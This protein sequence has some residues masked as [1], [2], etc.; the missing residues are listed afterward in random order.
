MNDA[1]F[2]VLYRQM[3]CQ[4]CG[5]R[6]D[7]EELDETFFPEYRAATPFGCLECGTVTPVYGEKDD[8]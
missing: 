1:Y 2:E 8:E 7:H 5:W 4:T 6:T 3:Y